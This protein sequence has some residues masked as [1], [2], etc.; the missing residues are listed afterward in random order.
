M[1]LFFWTVV[2]QLVPV[3]QP[4]IFFA[5]CSELF[6][7]LFFCSCFSLFPP[8]PPPLSICPT[9]GRRSEDRGHFLLPSPPPPPSAGTEVLNRVLVLVVVLVSCGSPVAAI[10]KSQSINL[11]ISITAIC[12]S[13][14]FSLQLFRLV[15]VPALSCPTT[16]GGTQN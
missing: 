7:L 5:S 9:R 14:S 12:T 16:N 11:S 1:P 8:S 15:L 6:Q 3:Q 10:S 4:Q 2:L 13:V